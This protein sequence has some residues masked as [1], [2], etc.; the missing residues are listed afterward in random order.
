MVSLHARP[1]EKAEVVAKAQSG[2]IARLDKCNTNW[3]EIDASGADGWLPK[4]DIW[5]VD[6]DETRD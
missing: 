5:G 3:C 4:T 1:D 2:A 6:A